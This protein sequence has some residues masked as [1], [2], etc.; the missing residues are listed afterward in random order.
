MYIYEYGFTLL[1]I[2]MYPCVLFSS[3]VFENNFLLANFTYVTLHH[4]MSCNVSDGHF[5]VLCFLKSKFYAIY[6]VENHFQIRTSG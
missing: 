3:S 5:H 2:K 6:N 4:E 1:H